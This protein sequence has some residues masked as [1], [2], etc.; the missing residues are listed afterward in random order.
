MPSGFY[1]R[2]PRKTKKPINEIV[3][4]LPVAKLEIPKDDSVFGIGD[5]VNTQKGILK[6]ILKVTKDDY[7]FMHLKEEYYTAA[8]G[9]DCILKGQIATQPKYIF[10]K[11]HYLYQ[12]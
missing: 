9:L 3:R 1:V 6:V 11:Y 12:P 8:T 10:D 5:L 7:E 2:K 4:P